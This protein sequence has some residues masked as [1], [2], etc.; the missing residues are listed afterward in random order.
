M[1]RLG[2]S[3]AKDLDELLTLIKQREMHLIKL[4]NLLLR[5][6]DKETTYDSI[7]NKID[8]DI[9][10]LEGSRIQQEDNLAAKYTKYNV[11]K[12]EEQR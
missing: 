12:P 3:L 4:L 9:I 5:L 1:S 8:Y 7:E 2:L 10:K 6:Q 11:H